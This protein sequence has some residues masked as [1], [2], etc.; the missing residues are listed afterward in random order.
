MVGNKVHFLSFSIFI[1]GKDLLLK[2]KR[3]ENGLKKEEKSRKGREQA[4]KR[5]ATGTQPAHNKKA[6]GREGYARLSSS[7]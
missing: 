7:W 1:F 6:I 4:G 3:S 2:G 5:H